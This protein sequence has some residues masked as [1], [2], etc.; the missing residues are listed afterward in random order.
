VARNSSTELCAG[1]AREISADCLPAAC[2]GG[3]TEYYD[4]FDFC[5]KRVPAHVDA[6]KGRQLRVFFMTDG[7]DGP[8]ANRRVSDAVDALCSVHDVVAYTYLLFGFT[9]TNPSLD[10][11]NEKFKQRGV[12]PT[13]FT[14]TGVDELE[15]AMEAF[16]LPGSAY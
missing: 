10:A 8:V 12:E 3:Y 16:T 9:G 4:A 11:I 14:A 2:P 15:D 7:G 6:L 1:L 13:Q 5:A